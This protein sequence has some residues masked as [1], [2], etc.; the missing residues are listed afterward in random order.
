MTHK[1]DTLCDAQ[2]CKKQ[3]T[4][5]IVFGNRAYRMCDHHHHLFC[6]TKGTEKDI[7]EVMKCP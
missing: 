3:M 2:K 7:M 6:D 4:T 1:D 5:T